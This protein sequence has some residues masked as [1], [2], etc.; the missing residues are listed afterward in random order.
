MSPDLPATIDLRPATGEDAHLLWRWANEPSVREA[1]FRIDPIGWDEHRRWLERRLA[2]PACR[3]WIVHADGLPAAQVRFELDANGDAEISV[4]VDP[5][6]RGR[7]IGRRAVRRACLELFSE[8]GARSVLARVKAGN[9]SSLHL[10]ASAGFSDE[11]ADV[12]VGAPS[13]RLRLPNPRLGE[14]APQAA[15]GSTQ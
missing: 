7:G 15:A 10:F 6:R 4:S 11:G 12:V 14:P 3:I 9:R 1:S 13:R 5:A 8:T 2:S